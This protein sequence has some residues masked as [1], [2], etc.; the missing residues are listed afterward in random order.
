MLRT[1]RL[2][3]RALP[4]VFAVHTFA[5]DAAA[6]CG[7]Y[8][9][10]AD[11]KLFNNATEVVL[12]R[13]GT[14]T[15]LSMANNYQGPPSDFA[16]VVPVPVVLQKENVKTL[17]AD[18]FDRLDRLAAPRLVEYWEQD[19]CSPPTRE[20]DVLVSR[21]VSVNESEDREEEAS[22]RHGVTIEARFSVAEYNILIL[23]AKD[24]LGLDLFL[25]EQHYKI[26]SGAEPYLRP[27][28]A[29]GS[30]FF[31]A[32][33]DASK[34]K[35][36]NGQ[37][38]LSPLR[39]HYD[40]ESFSLPVRLGLINSAGTQDLIVHVLARSRHEVAN[41]ENFA[42]PTNI[43]V[44]EN[45]RERFGSFYAAL[46]DDVLAK[47]P[48][49]VVT[50][51]AWSAGSCDPCPTP[52][53]DVKDLAT[54][55]A[56]VLPGIE[57]QKEVPPELAYSF[58]LTRLHA[59]Y[60]KDALGEDLTFR[61]APPIAGGNGVPDQNGKMQPGAVP[62][63]NNSFQGRYVMLHPWDGPMKCEN[64]VRG[65]WG[66]PIN[67]VAGPP[68]VATKTAFVPR[69]AEL[70]SFLQ[71]PGEDLAAGPEK[72]PSGPV[73]EQPFP[74]LPSSGGCASCTTASA[75]NGLTATFSA[76]V[77]ALLTLFRRGNRRRS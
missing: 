10:G 31:V 14:R 42:I 32:K 60:N 56:D 39:F 33:V 1:L 46:F 21:T 54:L 67:Q 51:Y 12:M 52:P 62:S 76:S 29:S 47:H 7:F 18:I 57:G 61:A 50:E 27:Y 6:F 22:V 71:A 19:P 66:G 58:T 75:R 8:V 35:F 63:G 43:R 53:L 55:G 28:V 24:S 72:L 20:Y 41:Y 36:E 2:S 74:L 25:R 17:P 26:P 70:A 73:T 45:V 48:G 69:G 37:A 59:R 11:A 40:S 64:P 77:L 44:N 49:A 23:S 65:R 4:L 15:V 5:P 34:V 38:M 30:K 3:L 68:V 16:M 13:D 9:A